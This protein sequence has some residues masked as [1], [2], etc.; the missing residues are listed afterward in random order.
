M[1]ELSK[2]ELR[3]QRAAER[4]WKEMI[5]K[6]SA[7]DAIIEMDAFSEALLYKATEPVEKE[8]EDCVGALLY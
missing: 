1:Q 3:E 7:K 8:E 4:A 5:I 6:Y 2:Q